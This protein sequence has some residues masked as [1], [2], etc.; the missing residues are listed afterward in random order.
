MPRTAGHITA[1][2]LAGGYGV[3]L[4]AI[5]P[6]ED[7]LTYDHL[8]H[9][10]GMTDIRKLR[11]LSVG[12]L[13][14][15]AMIFSAACNESRDTGTVTSKSDGK[16]STAPPAEAVEEKDMALV[17]VV[18][19]IPGG[20]VSIWAG[21]SAAF[22]G[23]AYQKA[24]AYREIPDNMFNFQIKSSAEG[25]ALAENRE[26]LKDGGHY[27]IVA[28]PDEGGADKRNLRVL[29]DELKPIAA[30]K[31]R[32]RF[33]NGVPGDTDVDLVIAGREDPLFDGVNFKSEAGWNEF[34]PITGTLQVRP[35]N[36]KTTLA[37]LSN[38]SL[39]GGKSYTFVLTGKAGK[40]N[41][42]KIEDDV[43][44]QPS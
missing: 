6:S 14:T 10:V 33:I 12:V 25:Q 22:S 24:T 35:D 29:D 11:G 30:D 20:A 32:V 41:L 27:T 26:N 28:L 8:N 34:D 7:L 2:G 23:V 1:L 44:R 31:A 36:A 39:E 19:A 37:K 42:I 40:L 16:T 5:A 9:E 38:V 17:R 4:A 21:D 3:G 43:A 18:N 15:G 13:A